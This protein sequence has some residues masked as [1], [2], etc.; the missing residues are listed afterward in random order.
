[1]PPIRVLLVDDNAEFL[2]SAA[3]FLSV[4]PRIVIVGCARSGREALDQVALLHPDLVLM[5][6]AMPGMNGLK[7]TRRI[8]AQPDAPHVIILTLYD[9]AEYRTAAEAMGADGFVPKW[10]FGTKLLSLIHTLFPQAQAKP[11]A[12]V[13]GG[14]NTTSQTVVAVC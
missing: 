4:D 12:R 8:K 1:M 7:A 6:M 9:N 13:E 10:E 11:A 5:D 2:Q 3:R 14:D